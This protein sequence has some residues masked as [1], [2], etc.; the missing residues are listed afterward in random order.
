MPAAR[1]LYKTIA[2]R[3]MI[4]LASFA[5]NICIAR[6]YGAS[7]SGDFFYQISIYSL[8][9]LVLSLSLESGLGYYA[10]NNNIPVN[11]LYSLSI[12]W[13]GI[14]SLFLA[15]LFYFLSFKGINNKQLLYVALPFITG[16]ILMA[17]L[18]GIFYAR[19]H[20]VLPNIIM[21]VFYGLLF[22]LLPGFLFS[23]LSPVQYLQFYQWSFLGM[24]LIMALTLY[25][26][27][28]A[29]FKWEWPSL[30]AIKP[31]ILFSFW[32]WVGNIV[33]FFLYRV[34]YWFVQHYCNAS[35][36]GNY[37]Q[38]SRLAQVFFLIPSIAASVIF[39]LTASGD[40]KDM[41]KMIALVSRLFFWTYIAVCFILIISGQ[42]LFPWLF[43]QSYNQMYIP[44]LLLVPGILSLSMLYPITAYNAGMNRLKLNLL[45]CLITLAFMLAGD[46]VLVPQYGINAAAAVSSGSYILLQIVL[47]YYL[48]NKGI[49]RRSSFFML[50]KNDFS[51]LKSYFTASTKN[52]D[53]IQ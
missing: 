31:V 15:A 38:V 43:G 48:G 35:E 25:I 19:K 45:A 21:L 6:I 14:A 47:F 50:Q 9:I 23:F 11:R 40:K 36:L 42:W 8:I 34:D 32:A 27:D 17:F 26:T 30:N 44:F 28:I 13:V 20:F 52:Q 1:Y 5:L 7:I 39:P 51:L 4:Y 37:I 24:A 2:W 18:V 16:N 10:S 46:Y 53:G 33:F 3:G 41:L 12:I 29:A 49:V 22:I